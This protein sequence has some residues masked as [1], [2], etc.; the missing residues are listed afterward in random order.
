MVEVVA[1]TRLHFGLFA[2]G[3]RFG[4]CGLMLDR[5]TV[6]VRVGP[7]NGDWQVGGRHGERAA[8]FLR[9]A[10]G[11]ESHLPGRAWVVSADGPPEH[12]GLG[13]GTAL[14][15]AVSVAGSLA[16]RLPPSADELAVRV[17]RGKRSGIGLHGFRHGGFLV[18]AGKPA[19]D[20]LP[21]LAGRCD[22]PADWRVV[23]IRP[24]VAWRWS[25]DREQAAFDRPR[26]PAPPRL[27]DLATGVLLPAV[28]RA[29]FGTFAPA[30]GEFNRLA[31]EPFA[32]DQGGAYAGPAVTAVV[33]AV[34][35]WGWEGV[36]QSSWGPTVFAVCPDEAS[37]RSLADR[38][39]SSFPD[40]D[41]LTITA[42]RNGGATFYPAST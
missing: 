17:G 1:G 4:G 35:D 28:G 29:D 15:L 42:A 23:L 24:R 11:G 12:V 19:P 36:G 25:G 6:S 40:L 3:G 39:R 26:P 33:E 5:P 31:G 14:G 22:F 8:K 41:D 10:V 27:A 9:L 37:A 18:D 7:S 13:V 30:L 32:A 20:R 2:A 21:E 16:E 38:C 34:R